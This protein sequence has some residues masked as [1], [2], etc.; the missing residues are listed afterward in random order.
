MESKKE[1]KKLEDCKGVSI[2]YL[3]KLWGCSYEGIAK[4]IKKEKIPYF[5]TPIGKR[6]PIKWILEQSKIK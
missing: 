6:I 4:A 2:T 1:S 3:A 5:E